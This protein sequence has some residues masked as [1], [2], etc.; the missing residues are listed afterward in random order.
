MN[1]AGLLQTEKTLAETSRD[2]NHAPRDVADEEGVRSFSEDVS[3]R[4][5]RVTLLINNAESRWKA[6]S[7]KISLDDFRWLMKYQLLGHG[8]WRQSIS[9]HC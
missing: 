3:K 2:R 8:I 4:H 9:C 7:R 1:E 5:G 6:L